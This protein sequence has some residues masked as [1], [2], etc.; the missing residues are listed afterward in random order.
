MKSL[1]SSESSLKR[2]VAE[3]SRCEFSCF[4]SS[5]FLFCIK[6]NHFLYLHAVLLTHFLIIVRKF[7]TNSVLLTLNVV[8]QKF[9]TWIHCEATPACLV[10]TPSLR[11]DE[12]LYGSKGVNRRTDSNTVRDNCVSFIYTS[13]LTPHRSNLIHFW[14]QYS[15]VSSSRRF[16]RGKKFSRQL[17]V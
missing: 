7:F 16:F 12:I 11:G 14:I 5:G 6:I 10:A 17:V 8:Y 4:W 3:V 9:S 13:A 2:K 15:F 1:F